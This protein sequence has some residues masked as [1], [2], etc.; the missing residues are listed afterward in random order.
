VIQ[1]T[2]SGTRFHLRSPLIVI[3]SGEDFV[4]FRIA[5]ETTAL[6]GGEPLGK[7]WVE[8]IVIPTRDTGFTVTAAR[9]NLVPDADGE[10]QQFVFVETNRPVEV[11]AFAKEVQAWELPQP[12]GNDGW[13]PRTVTA[14]VLA[15]AKRVPLELVSD[16]S[17]AP[18]ANTVSFRLAPR[19]PGPLWI[20]VPAG[21]AVL[22][23]FVLGADFGVEVSIPAFR[24]MSAFSAKAESSR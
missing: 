14:D 10:P 17:A 21:I 20:R 5:A 13:S 23:G 1:A 15:R 9:S 2:K 22:G 8:R 19:S 11:A 16:E 24:R 6:S 7:E 12:V 18:V 4:R 3:P